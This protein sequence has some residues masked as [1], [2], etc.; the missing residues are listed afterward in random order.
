MNRLLSILFFSFLP[1]SIVNADSAIDFSLSNFCYEQP[2]VQNRNDV[3]F[4]PNQEIGIT[5]TSIC[6]FKNGGGQYHS[7]GE[8]V[9][10][11]K[12]GKW[13]YWWRDGSKRMETIWNKGKQ[14]SHIGWYGG[15]R[16]E[17]TYKDG[18]L[19]T[20]IIYD[21]NERIVDES[22]HNTSEYSSYETSYYYYENGILEAS[23]SM[24]SR[25]GKGLT[26]HGKSEEWY[27]NGQKK[28]ES[29][30]RD[31]VMIG[32]WTDWY[33]NGQMMFDI[34][35]DENGNLDG[36]HRYWFKN[37]VLSGEYN[38]SKGNYISGSSWDETGQCLAGECLNE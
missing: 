5:D 33:D 7:R 20:Q 3:Y 27:E 2:N 12:D 18:I 16:A 10:G 13:I 22:T 37:G 15:R 28:S 36:T 26:M 4:L 9:N 11:N 25:H 35:N 21:S 8:L 24:I 14:V 38:Y 34:V 30:Y 19:D 1:F 32:H 29:H 23:M 17:N 31:G 6:I